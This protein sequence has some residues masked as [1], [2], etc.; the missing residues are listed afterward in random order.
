[1]PAIAAASLVPTRAEMNNGT[2]LSTELADWSGWVVDSELLDVQPM[3]SP[4]RSKIPGTLISPDSSLTFYTSKTGV[5]VRTVFSR[6]VTGWIMFLDGG[7]VVS[8]RAE[9]YPVTVASVSVLRGV[10]AADNAG[11]KAA[12][13]V[14]VKFAI[15]AAPAQNVT[16]PA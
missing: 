2:N 15:T 8:N 12:S 11:A 5:D 13:T 7:D 16:V 9:V 3:N 1:M 4:Y 14:T 10:L 6:A